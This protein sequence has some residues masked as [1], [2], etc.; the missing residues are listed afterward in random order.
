[1]GQGPTFEVF[2]TSNPEHQTSDRA[3]LACF[4]LHAPRSVALADCLSIRLVVEDD[5]EK[6]TVHF[7]FAVVCNEAQLPELIHEE[8]ES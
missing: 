8:T 7:H 5:T 3:F 6:G 4:A 2:G 1:M